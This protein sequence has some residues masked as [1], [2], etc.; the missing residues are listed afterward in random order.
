MEQRLAEFRAAR[1]RTGLAAQPSTGSHGAQIPGEKAEAAATLKA[2][3]SWLKQFLVWKPK[4]ASAWAQPGLVQEVAQ[5]QGST[6]QPPQNTVIPLPSCWDQSFLTNITFLKAYCGYVPG[7]LSDVHIP[8]T[9]KK[10]L[11]TLGTRNKAEVTFISLM[12]ILH[13][14]LADFL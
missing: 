1:K 3:L 2:A 8:V 12:F 9:W 13:C 7:T 4:P 5:P 14:G 11:K 6:S 10:P